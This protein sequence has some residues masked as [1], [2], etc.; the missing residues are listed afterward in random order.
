MRKIVLLSL[1]VSMVLVATAWAAST[2]AVVTHAATA[3]TNSGAVL[4]ATVNPESDS[5]A[6]NF[7]YGPTIAYGAYS[8]TGKAGGTKAVSVNETLA[9]LDPGTVYHYR[10]EASNKLGRAYGLDHTFTTTGHPLP[11]AIT[12]VA[13]GVGRTTAT[14]TGTVVTQDETTSSYFELGTTT[15]YGV[16]TFSQNVTA[17][18]TPTGV[19]YTVTGLAPGTT[20]HYRLVADHAGTA[21]EYG[22]DQTFTTVP[23]VRLRSRLTAHTTPV[24]V[25]HKPYAFTTLGAVVPPRSLPAGVGCSGVVVVRFLLGHRVVAY[26]TLAVQANCTFSTPVSFRRLVDR[27]PTQL[28]VVAHFR[29]NSYLRSASSRGQRVGLG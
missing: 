23:S 18:T 24:H 2:P 8:K 10:I 9:G 22:A 21:L 15:N 29:G 27:T 7:Q 26:R 1:A 16:Q 13:S 4:N 20:F 12:G 11:A 19:S 6:Y 28:T 25:R 3:V 5:T 14:L 17:A